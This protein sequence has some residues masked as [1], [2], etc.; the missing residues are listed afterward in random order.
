V[1]LNPNIPAASY[2]TGDAVGTHGAGLGSD[3]VGTPRPIPQ[4]LGVL[5]VTSVGPVRQFEKL[6]PLPPPAVVKATPRKLPSKFGAGLLA[7]QSA[8]AHPAPP[9]PTEKGY[10]VPVQFKGVV[11]NIEPRATAANAPPFPLLRATVGVALIA[12]GFKEGGPWLLL[13]LA[14]AALD[15]SAIHKWRTAGGSV[16]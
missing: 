16:T 7:M 3:A 5:A 15:I 6:T 10:P 9:R 2:G 4:G 1:S 8:P 13:A 11:T 12:I 14:G